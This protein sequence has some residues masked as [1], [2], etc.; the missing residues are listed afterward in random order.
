MSTIV[1]NGSTLGNPLQTLLMAEGMEPGTAPSYQLAKIIYEFHV[2]GAKMVDAPISMAQ[3]QARKI[4]VT[5]GPEDRLVEAFNE[6]WKRIQADQVI[7]DLMSVS[8]RYG[9]GTVGLITADEDPNSPVDWQ[10]IWEQDIAFN[11]WDPLNTSGSLVLNQNPTAMDFMKYE[12]VV[13]QGVKYHR[14]RTVVKFNERPVYLGWTTSAFGYVGR[15]VYQRPLYPL[16]SFI[17][18]MLT[19]D[20]VVRKAGVLIAALKGVGAIVDNIQRFMWGRKR[21]VV[22]D[23]ETGNVISIQPDE[24]IETLN[25]Q[26]LDGAYGMARTNIL[27]NIATAADM[28]ARLL[29]NETMVSGFGEGTEDAKAIAQYIDRFRL[30]MLPVY[31]FLD[32]VVR[33]RAWNRNFFKS[34]QKDFPELQRVPYETAFVEWQNG[35]K[36]EWPNLL[37]E[38][39]SEKAK[40]QEVQ[41]KALIALIQV[42]LPELDPVNKALVIQWATDNLNQLPLLFPASLNLEMEQYQDWQEEQAEKAQAMQQ[43]GGE[44]KEPPAPPPFSARD[45][46]ERRPMLNPWAAGPET[47]A[48]AK[49]VMRE[50]NR[51][52]ERLPRAA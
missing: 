5:P 32:R 17:Q 29:E 11:I 8:R 44:E 16:K 35:F 26:N 2:L 36:A 28:P 14:S 18:S 30:E 1:I 45:S 50:L 43:M 37:A 40:Q 51:R 33:Y 10:K 23:A 9:A 41:L 34:L 38:P 20:L 27:K 7:F 39:E 25:L 48:V 3:S 52:L 4:V 22:K 6:E 13:V 21:E 15:S 24:R 47:D 42:L 12:Q 46:A 19:D 49:T 31:A